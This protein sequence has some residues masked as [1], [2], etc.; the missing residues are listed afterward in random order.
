MHCQIPVV[1]QLLKLYNHFHLI[2]KHLVLLLKLSESSGFVF[3]PIA[4]DVPRV[5]VLADSQ[6]NRSQKSAQ[7]AKKAKTQGLCQKYC[8]HCKEVITPL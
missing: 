8:S 2:C 3:F 1:S 4:D 7:V 6:L 5:S